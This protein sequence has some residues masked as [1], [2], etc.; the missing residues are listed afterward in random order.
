MLAAGLL[1][2]QTSEVQVIRPEKGAVVRETYISPSAPAPSSRP[3]RDWLESRP[4]L[5]RLQG[6]F[7]RDRSEPAGNI[8]TGEPPLLEAKP[9]IP[10]V[11][12]APTPAP[13]PAADYLKKLPMSQLTPSQKSEVGETIS[14]VALTP[15]PGKPSPIAPALE[16]KIGRDEKFAWV[17]GQLVVEGKTFKLYYATPETVDAHN[18]VVQLGTSNVDMRDLRNG[19][20]VSA[21]GQLVRGRGT[22]TYQ[23]NSINLIERPGR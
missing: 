2:A 11:A 7:R 15:G 12:P 3:L 9:G 5:S 20:L 13:A 16:N 1:L 8:T 19:D 22:A 14:T 17:T 6:L 21:E 23:V 18:G 10:T 4:V